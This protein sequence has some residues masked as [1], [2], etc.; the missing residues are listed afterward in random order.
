M[1]K[2]LLLASGLGT[3]MRPITLTTPK[4]LVEV[5]GKPL[6]E[7]VIDGLNQVGVNKI[8]IAVGYLAEKFNYL[9]DK[10]SNVELI[11][12]D[13][14]LT[15]NNISSFKAAIPF[16]EGDDC[17]ICESDL[18]LQEPSVLSNQSESYYCGLFC[19]DETDDWCFTLD[20]DGFINRVGKKG[21]HCH[22][23]VGLSFLKAHDI[24]TLSEAILKTYKTDNFKDLFWDDV[25]NQNLDKLK[26]KIHEVSV[27][28]VIEVDNVE[29]LEE[30]RKSFQNKEE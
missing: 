12:N 15:V 24:M 17:Y 21:K 4:P 22:K 8:F 14:Y 16:I 29:E 7:T 1:A 6:I 3:R 23:M 28:S 13:E 20:N 27:G 18:Y 19:D 30:L 26:L 2:A 5:N 10:Y 11:L 9:K 25:V